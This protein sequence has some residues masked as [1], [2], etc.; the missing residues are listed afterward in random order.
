M[1]KDSHTDKHSPLSLLLSE[2]GDVSTPCHTAE[3]PKIP[4]PGARM[5]MRE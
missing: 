4:F 5:R 1:R 3:D 2:Q